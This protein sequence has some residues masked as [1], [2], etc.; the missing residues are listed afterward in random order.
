MSTSESQSTIPDPRPP[1][2]FRLRTLLLL[3]VVLAS[4]LAVFGGWGVVVFGLVV[5]LAIPIHR[6]ESFSS[7]MRRAFLLICLLV[8]VV[9]LRLAIG[10]VGN[11]IREANC[12]ANLQ[13]ICLALE[14]YRSTYGHLP[15]AYLVDKNG[16]PMHSWRVLIL[17]FLGENAL[18]KAY[19]FTEPWDGPKNKKL[20]ADCPVYYACPSDPGTNLPTAGR[21]SYVA[22]VGANAAWP[23]VKAAKPGPMNFP[24]GDRKT[25]MLVESADSGIAWTEPRD[26]AL[27]DLA[28]TQASA[29]PAAVLG[30]HGP[31]DGFF[32]RNDRR[33]ACVATVDGGRFHLRPSNFSPPELRRLLQVGGFD[34]DEFDGN[35]DLSDNAWHFNWPN[36]A[37]LAVWLLSVGMLL[38][39]AV[40]SRKP[41]FVPLPPVG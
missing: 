16:T 2:Q 25:I 17:P 13:Y 19:D 3:F 10:T 9:F 4:L 1:F 7:A 34:P 27:D 12:Y 18:Y 14:Q 30:Y 29:T 22:V 21:T 41:K 20:M 28:A 38:T 35:S 36:I 31:E 37:A 26:L 15:P 6:A 39:K 11:G 32:F 24:C 8:F 23:D 5:G 33:T 40:R